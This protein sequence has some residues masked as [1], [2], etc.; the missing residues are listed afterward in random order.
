[1]GLSNFIV[2]DEKL[3]ELTNIRMRFDDSELAGISSIKSRRIV[4]IYKIRVIVERRLP[5]ANANYIILNV[6][7]HFDFYNKISKPACV[8]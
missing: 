1:M 2:K 6:R 7:I 8:S 5:T 4:W 3:P